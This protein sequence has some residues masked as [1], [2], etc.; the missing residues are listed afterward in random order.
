MLNVDIDDDVGARVRFRASLERDS[1]YDN[2]SR[3]W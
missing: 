3:Q 2:V 1:L